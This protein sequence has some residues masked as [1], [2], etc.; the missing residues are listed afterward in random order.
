MKEKL[1]K[2][3][4]DLFFYIVGCAIYSSAITMLVSANEISPGGLTGIATVLNYLFSLPS[5]FTLFMLNI[6]ILIIGFI[7]FGGIFIIKTSVV[8]ALMSVGLTITDLFLPAFKID[9]IL[10]SV[11][12]GILMGLGISLIML[13]G[14][15][16]GGVDILAKLI[17]RRFRHLTVGKLILFMD[18]VV[19]TLATIAYRN[20]ESAL[21]SVLSLYASSYIMD[22]VLYGGDKGK[23]VY[24]VTDKALDIC[25]EITLGLS[26]GV[27]V[28][29]A[30]GGYTGKERSLL[31]CT[32][33]RHEVS[34]L[35]SVLDKHDKNAFIVVADAGEIIG[36]GFKPMS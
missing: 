11:F 1:R 33:R 30:R 21:Y 31:L 18:A 14:A 25:R 23:L 13:R 15:T 4:T 29:S 6:P 28:L 19:I 3:A 5:G 26:R 35:Y 7:K 10:A 27:T 17:N 12:G 24:I 16:T 9:K 2:T 32:V 20:I 34:E 36:E 22:T 8:T